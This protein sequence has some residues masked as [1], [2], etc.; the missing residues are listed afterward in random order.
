M[1]VTSRSTVTNAY[2]F[3]PVLAGPVLVCASALA[4]ADFAVAL[5]RPSRMTFEALVATALLVCLVFAIKAPPSLKLWAYYTTNRKKSQCEY[6]I[7]CIY[8]QYETQYIVLT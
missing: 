6:T 7:Y 8:A 3:L 5:Y 2:F 4:A 1:V